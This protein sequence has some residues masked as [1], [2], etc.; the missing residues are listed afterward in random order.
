[1]TKK[2]FV[3]EPAKPD[4]LIAFEAGGGALKTELEGYHSGPPP[5]VTEPQG[6]IYGIPQNLWFSV[7]GEVEFRIVDANS[8]D[9]IWMALVTKKIQDPH[10][11]M[12]DV[13]K[14]VSQI[15]SAAFKSFP[16]NPK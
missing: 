13:D 8:N 2:G 15:V 16:P 3:E 12:K 7:N 14:Q 1:L 9:S 11:A 10:K 5:R 4:F 6:P